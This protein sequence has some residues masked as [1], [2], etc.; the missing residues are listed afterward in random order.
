MSLCMAKK[1]EAN[2]WQLQETQDVMLLARAL[3]IAVEALMQGAD[4]MQ[5][6]TENKRELLQKASERAEEAEAGMSSQIVLL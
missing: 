3:I 5:V 6:E 1:R 4:T 2:M